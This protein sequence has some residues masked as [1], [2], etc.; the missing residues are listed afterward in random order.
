MSKKMD[1]RYEAYITDASA[2]YDGDSILHTYFRVPGVSVVEG[3]SGELL[4][5]IFAKDGQLWVHAEI[6]LAGIDAPE[7]H[8]R[9]LLPDG[10]ERGPKEIAHEAHLAWQARSV[11]VDAITAAGLSFELRNLQKGKYSRIVA[12]VWVKDDNGVFLNMS[13]VLLKKGLAYPYDGST[14]HRWTLNGP[15]PYPSP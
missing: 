9:H 7:R 12:Q 11:L 10:T 14:K 8:P 1:R 2:I 13:D 3:V 4:P 5:E 6:R 15:E